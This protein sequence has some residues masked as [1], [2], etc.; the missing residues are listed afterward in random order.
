MKFQSLQLQHQ[1]KKPQ[2]ISTVGT[3]VTIL[4]E[5]FFNNST[6][7]FLGDALS[8]SITSANFF[9]WRTWNCI[10]YSIEVMPK[11]YSTVYIDG[12]KMSDPSS[13]SGDFD[14][15]NILTSQISRAEILKG[16]QS[17]IY[18]S[19]AIEG[20]YIFLQ[21][22]ENLVFKRILNMLLVLMIP[23]IF[24]P[25][26]LVAMKNQIILLDFKDFKQMEYLK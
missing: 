15:N 8:T 24:Q 3:S 20:Q 9:K 12:V 14:F 26:F 22:K 1:V 25:H 13:V 17:S 23:T 2:S 10:S 16:N 19:G 5:E 18:G 21:N 11:R 4:N 6:E 7:H